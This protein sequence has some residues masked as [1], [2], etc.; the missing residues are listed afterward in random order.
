[1]AISDDERLLELLAGALGSDQPVP[2]ALTSDA[3]AV[4]TW[5]TVDAELMTLGFDSAV[6]ELAGVRSTGTPVRVLRFELG[7]VEVEVEAHASG[8]DGWVT[9]ATVDRVDLER[10]GQ[11]DETSEVDEHGRFAF[12]TAEPGP[13]RLRLRHGDWDRVTEWLLLCG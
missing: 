9:G 10:P 12:P 6:D 1:M 2:E 8:I 3:R 4:F 7:A 13:V 5:R 11:P